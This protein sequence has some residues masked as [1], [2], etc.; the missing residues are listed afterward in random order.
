MTRVR[1]VAFGADDQPINAVEQERPEDST[2]L[3]HGE[4]RQSQ[5]EF[6]VLVKRLGAADGECIPEK[7]LD[8][9]NTDRKDA[10]DGMPPAQIVMPDL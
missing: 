6:R 2:D 4:V 7:V 9:K 10:G 3:Q 8:Q 1:E 5:E